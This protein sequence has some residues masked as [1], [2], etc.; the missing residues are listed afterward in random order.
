M[1]VLSVLCLVLLIS[2]FAAAQATVIGGY[3]SSWAPAY[4]PW[5]VP[6]SPLV[7]TPSVTLSV[8]SNSAVGASN[9]AFGMTAGATNSTLSMPN[10]APEGVYTVPVWYPTTE[11]NLASGFNGYEPREG[12]RGHGGGQPAFDFTVSNEGQGIAST[13]A[14]RGQARKATRTITNQDIDHV[15]ETNGLV[16]WDGKTEHI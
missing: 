10:Q 16:K 2:G 1:R 4:G 8:T 6:Y 9:N 15:N 12:R 14:S 13:V 5:G 11:A 7:T 3:A